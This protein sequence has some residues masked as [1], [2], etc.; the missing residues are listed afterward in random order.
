M[1]RAHQES[2]NEVA[3]P[4]LVRIR[5]VFGRNTQVERRGGLV[6]GGLEDEAPH[7][8]EY[9]ADRDGGDKDGAAAT[10][11]CSV[12]AIPAVIKLGPRAER[13][14]LGQKRGDTKCHF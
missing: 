5:R 3:G 2:W 4:N 9:E 14:V 1:V 7:L 13:V 12:A 10:Q 6:V 8:H 11:A